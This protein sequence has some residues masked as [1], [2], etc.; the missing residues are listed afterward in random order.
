MCLYALATSLKGNWHETLADCLLSSSITSG[1]LTMWSSCKLA[2][3]QPIHV[4]TRP[5][6][7]PCRLS[8]FDVNMPSTRWVRTSF[9]SAFLTN[10][11]L[12]FCPSRGGGAKYQSF[13]RQLVS[14]QLAELQAIASA[15]R[16]PLTESG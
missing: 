7:Q 16:A 5:P 15:H 13:V 10:E 6:S 14:N 4:F 8:L 2:K 9:K 11:A 12:P 3:I 1:H